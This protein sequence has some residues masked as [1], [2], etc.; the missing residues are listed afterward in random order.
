ML[1]DSMNEPEKGIEY[2][3]RA[4]QLVKSQRETRL[5]STANIYDTL[6]WAQYMGNKVEEAISSLRQSIAIEPSPDAYLHLV[7]AFI[8]A[9]KIP[10][11]RAAVDEGIRLS[12]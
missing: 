1:A 6:G 11:A 9:K 8:K 7:K 10:E 4:L 2:A 3:N 5:A 12:V